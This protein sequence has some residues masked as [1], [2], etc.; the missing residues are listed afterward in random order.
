MSMR[1]AWDRLVSREAS[2]GFGSVS[3]IR[4]RAAPYF[5]CLYVLGLGLLLVYSESNRLIHSFI[6]PTS[7]Q[8]VQLISD[9]DHAHAVV[10]CL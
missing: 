6:N 7:D 3:Y 8:L 9:G 2:D 4:V 1:R 5:F 10:C